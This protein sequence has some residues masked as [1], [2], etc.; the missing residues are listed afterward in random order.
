MIRIVKQGIPAAYRARV[1]METSAASELMKDYGGAYYTQM[2][3]AARER[4]PVAKQ[5]EL[6]NRISSL[7]SFVS[8]RSADISRTYMD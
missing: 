3:Q 4:S 2:L 5:I 8:G 1:W 6:V 7:E